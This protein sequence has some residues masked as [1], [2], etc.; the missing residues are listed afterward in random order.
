MPYFVNNSF[1]KAG[2][3]LGY[4]SSRFMDEKIQSL[5]HQAE[6]E[7][8]LLESSITGEKESIL[9]NLRQKL[10]YAEQQYD[11]TKK[12]YDRS[13]I[14]FQ[15]SVIPLN[16]FEIAE[17]TYENAKTAI[18]IAKSEY[19]VAKTGAKPEDIKLIEERISSFNKEI[20]FYNS[21]KKDYVLQSPF[22]GKMIF[23]LYSLNPVEY[24]SITDTSGYMLYAPIKF[25]YR[26]YLKL[27]SQVEFTVPGTDTTLNA[28]LLE[29][30]NNVE[31]INTSQVVFTMSQVDNTSDIIFP[32]L[33]V[34]CKFVC[35][36]ISPWEYAK[37]TL[38]IFMR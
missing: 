22:S 13:M 23:D 32:G 29:I 25:N 5:Q 28:H 14:L 26:V 16:E 9:E 35:D 21:M 27:N 17:S 8:K 10:I 3:T 12:N 18:D 24:I 4:I 20:G 11:L 37:R 2:D 36:E 34:Q 7:S 38:N 15:D 30:S 33:T 19:E 31:F 1:V 6:V